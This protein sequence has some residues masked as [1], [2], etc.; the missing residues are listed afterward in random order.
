MSGGG[1]GK[2]TSSTSTSAP[3]TTTTTTATS[4]GN[5]GSVYQAENQTIY[6]G[7]DAATAQAALDAGTAN[8]ANGINLIAETQSGAA[9]LISKAI[10][11]AA[12]STGQNA[13]IV[14][15]LTTP[16]PAQP[17]PGSNSATPLDL[18][19]IAPWAVAGVVAF[20]VFAKRK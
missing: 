12:A 11:L 18:T 14:S 20:F 15:S 13:A 2:S 7:T 16:P 5:T 3:Q 17:L 6:P 8:V 10:G 4:T 9:D 19:S 1:G